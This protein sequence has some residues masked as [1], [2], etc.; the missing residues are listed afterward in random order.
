L[1]TTVPVDSIHAMPRIDLRRAEAL[2]DRFAAPLG[3]GLLA[4]G[5]ALLV[6]P[7]PGLPFLLGGLAVLAPRRAW[8]RRARRRLRLGL[9]RIRR[10]DRPGPPGPRAPPRSGRR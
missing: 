4:V 5:G 9:S 7:G 1:R 2:L 8:A 10:R 6:L 3:Y